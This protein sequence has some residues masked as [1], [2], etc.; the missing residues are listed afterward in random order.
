MV[1]AAIDVECADRDALNAQHATSIPAICK[2]LPTAIEIRAKTVRFMMAAGFMDSAFNSA[3]FLPANSTA[4][5]VA[6]RMSI[7]VTTR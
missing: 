7:P 4:G 1:M 3:S 2:V 5:R 6:V